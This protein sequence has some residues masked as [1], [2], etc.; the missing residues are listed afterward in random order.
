[1]NVMIRRARPA[2]A[3]ARPALAA[4]GLLTAGL[5]AACGGPQAPDATPS[6]GRV[7]QLDIFAQC[8]RSHGE[9]DF[10]FV[11][12]QNLPGSSSSQP[13]LSI[14]GEAVP[15]IDPG[16]ARF[17][18]AMT[19]CRHLLPGGGPQPVSQKQKEQLLRAAACMRSHGFPDYPDPFFPSTG[20]I[21]EKP[22]PASI[23]TSSPQFQA[24]QK[25]CGA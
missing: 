10:Y 21:G 24:A 23:D 3:A 16:T 2:R 13:M 7:Q 9:P 22:L 19:A 14:M 4:I 17:Q 5:L 18:S 11:S 15:G 1:M 12:Q 8:M 6:A 20:G 25:T